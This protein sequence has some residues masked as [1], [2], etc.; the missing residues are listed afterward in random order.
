V[1]ACACIRA[2]LRECVCVSMCV[3]A[4]VRVRQH[5][6]RDAICGRR[7]V[8]AALARQCCY[9]KRRFSRRDPLLYPFLALSALLRLLPSFCAV[10]FCGV[11]AGSTCARVERACGFRQ[12]LWQCS[13]SCRQ[14]GCSLLRVAL[15]F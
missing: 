1:R 10:A 8:S 6:R 15:S 5:I 9:G 2:C 7:P 11:I 12:C 14:Y 4:C 13:L 3:C